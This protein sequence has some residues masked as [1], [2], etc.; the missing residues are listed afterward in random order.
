[1]LF[2]AYKKSYS[3]N[4]Q[5]YIKINNSTSKEKKEV[6]C[7]I[8]YTVARLGNEAREDTATRNVTVRGKRKDFRCLLAS[9]SIFF[10]MI[11]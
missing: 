1:M 3:Q 2:L 7:A 5:F 8:I 10:S 11:C 4:I 6:K 9:I